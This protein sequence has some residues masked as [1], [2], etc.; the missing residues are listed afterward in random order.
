MKRSYSLYEA[1]ARLS[2]II[3]QVREHGVGVTISYHGRPVAEI[4]PIGEQSADPVEARFRELVQS[5][6]I[7]PAR[8][9]GELKP[10]AKRP[11]ALDRFLA[12]RD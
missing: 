4:R 10:L 8:A 12:D 11:G 1:K 2:E 3:R 7:L 6:E 9:R 5:G